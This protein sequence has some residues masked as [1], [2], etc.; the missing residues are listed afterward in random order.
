ME[1]FPCRFSGK[2]DSYAWDE[3]KAIVTNISDWIEGK[4]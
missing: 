2:E 3:K 4:A 1:T